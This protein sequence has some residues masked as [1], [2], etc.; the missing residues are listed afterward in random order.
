MRRLCRRP[1]QLAAITLIIGLAIGAAT[2]IS[3]VVSGVLLR[4]LPFPHAERLYMLWQ[5]APGVGVE[6]DWFSPAQYFDLRERADCFEE[7]ALIQ[8]RNVTLS[9]DGLQAER[10]GALEVSSSFFDLLGILPVRGRRLEQADDLPGSSVKAVLS[11]RVF[12]SRFA[13]G[14]DVIGRSIA[15]DGRAVE[16]VGVL[17]ELPLD[18]KLLPSLVTIPYFDLLLSHPIRDPQFT[19]SGSENY[20]ILARTRPQATKSE[21][22]ASLLSLARHFAEDPG[23]LGAG[24]SA[25]SEYRIAAVP[26]LE[27]TVGGIRL[28]LM[29]L[30]VSTLLLLVIACANVADLLLVSSASRRKEY[31]VRSALG[32]PR[33]RL[34]GD[35]LSESLALAA[36]GWLM[37]LAVAWAALRAL[38]WAAPQ[39]LPRLASVTLDW[40]VLLFSGALCAQCSLLFGLAPAWRSAGVSPSEVLARSAGRTSSRSPWR[41]AASGLVVLQVA[42]SLMLATGAALTIR[43]YARWSERRCP[44]HRFPRAAARTF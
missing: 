7:S 14:K 21:I 38:H 37:G 33:R 9:G 39:D 34:L 17:P 43:T 2:A 19:T 40:K 35:A 24:L 3:S 11:Q 30:L 18:A 13:G 22:D 12:Q 31:G 8:G 15:L 28:P 16:V 44:A 25:G 41:S 1:G 27:Q 36:I 6:E 20:N 10:V 32:A 4:P 23:S 29:V 26:W 5:R 42:L